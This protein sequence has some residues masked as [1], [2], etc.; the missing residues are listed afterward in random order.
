MLDAN[1]DKPEIFCD[2]L[3]HPDKIFSLQELNDQSGKD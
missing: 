3:P 1:N 2:T